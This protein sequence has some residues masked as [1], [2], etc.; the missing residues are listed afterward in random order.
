MRTHLL[1]SLILATALPAFAADRC[2]DL[3]LKH[4]HEGQ[5][6]AAK[7]KV[8]EAFDS[9]EAARAASPQASL[10]WS[11][12]ASLFQTLSEGAAP[13][14][15][16]KLRKEA[17]SAAN[18]A[19]ALNP[20]DPLAQEALRHLDAD[21]PSPLRMRNPAAAKVLDEAEVFFTERRLPEALAKYRE[22]MVLDP[23]ISMPWVGAG[24]C[25][26]LQKQWKQ[27]EEMF[28]RATEIEPRNSQAWRFLADA[29]VQQDKRGE[30][31]RALLSAIAADPA[32]LPNWGK[33][34]QLRADAGLPLKP[35]KLYRGVHV[36][37]D[38]D[39]KYEVQMEQQVADRSGTPDSSFRLALALAE[40][41]ARIE[42]KTRSR[43]PFDIELEAW[44][45]AFRIIDEANAASGESLTDPALRQM[46]QFAKDGQLEA[47]ILMLLYRQSYRPAL[48]AWLAREPGGVKQF[49]DRY[50]IRP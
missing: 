10:P 40:T 14:D 19:L 37:L 29:L 32:Q 28:R 13:D 41:S 33:L 15:V 3:C 2:N 44:R 16:E 42:D 8:K 47:A 5:A 38:K 11:A 21:A 30:G 43:T 49:T 20:D 50:G 6:L 9:F 23:Q 18:R 17:R 22:A 24:D 26:F 1:L 34:A 4:F 27:A 36:V 48:D 12:A 25:Y 31:E 35:L 7:G 46:Q 39:G 45:G